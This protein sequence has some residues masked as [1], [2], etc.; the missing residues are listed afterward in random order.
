MPGPTAYL[1]FCNQHREEEKERLK[2]GGHEKLP[3]TVIAKALGE[4]WKALG[5][6]EKTKYREQAAKAAAEQAQEE[7]ARRHE[8]DEASEP[9][10]AAQA[11]PSGRPDHLPLSTVRKV[12][13]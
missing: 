12:R 11:G 6:D 10:A 3:V 7:Q 5:E 1:L 4:R 8:G 2:A 9:D 13:T